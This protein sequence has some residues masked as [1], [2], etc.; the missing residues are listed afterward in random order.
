MWS[1]QFNASRVII[2]EQIPQ[3]HGFNCVTRYVLRYPLFEGGMSLAVTRERI[4][5]R[6]AACALLLD[7]KSQQV[8]LIEQFRM[9][10]LGIEN[11]WMLEI[12]AG[13]I[14]EGESAHDCIEREIFE[15]TGLTPLELFPILEYYN[16]PGSS[17]EKT[18]MFVALVE[19]PTEP[20]YHGLKSEG[21]DIKVQS[22]AI[23]EAYSLVNEKKIV[24]VTTIVA[25]QWLKIHHEAILAGQ[26]QF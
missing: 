22:F 2:D 12:V 24:N 10:P 26:R 19:A 18:Q 25:L 8:V 6:P 15:E 3:Y 23:N 21:E 1:A 20:R 9:G 14:D 17:C 5:R 7:L 11:P 16:S 13:L 4:E